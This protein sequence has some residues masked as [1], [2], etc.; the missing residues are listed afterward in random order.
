[1]LH[2]ARGFKCTFHNG[3]LCPDVRDGGAT[4]DES[5]EAS[6]KILAERLGFVDDLAFY[7][8]QCNEGN[9]PRFREKIMFLEDGD[10][11][12]DSNDRMYSCDWTETEACN[13]VHAEGFDWEYSRDF[14]L[15]K[16]EEHA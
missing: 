8:A 11:G 15:R 5:F 9:G 3:E 14:F 7:L 2:V 1:M 6:G 16:Y 12:R 13:E 10:A 4:H